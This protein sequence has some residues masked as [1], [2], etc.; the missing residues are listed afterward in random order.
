MTQLQ[1][2]F[3]V[4]MQLV[5]PEM[6][7][8]WLAAM[9]Y[10][11]Q[12]DV[13]PHHVNQLAEAMERD[14]FVPATSIYV[15]H[16]QGN[17]FLLD[18]QHRLSAIV[19][20]KKPQWFGVTEYF[21]ESQESIAWAYGHLDRNMVRSFAALVKAMELDKKADI[22]PA[23]YKRLRA[24]IAFLVSGCRHNV[25]TSKPIND[26][27]LIDYTLTY[28][29][30]MRSFVDL[31][32]NAESRMRYAV[33]RSSSLAIVLLSLRF[34]APYAALRG[35]PSVTEF[36]EGVI[37]DDGIQLGDPRKVAN[38]HLVA[39]VMNAS[40]NHRVV[41]QSVVTPP[42]SS[43]YLVNCFNAYMERRTLSRTNVLDAMSDIRMYGVPVDTAAWVRGE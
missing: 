27:D 33:L 17:Q 42:Y 36:W 38:R 26:Q 22:T 40:T 2:Q 15:A 34:S 21:F 20:C 25:S 43:R 16:F 35:D 13:Q 24:G 28:A 23:N 4:K 1:P 39:S 5:T 19:R 8:Q 37:F 6:A 10:E 7:Q 9:P 18:G 31:L 12:R 3:T 41:G 11:M 29:P 30:H 32:K 14:Q